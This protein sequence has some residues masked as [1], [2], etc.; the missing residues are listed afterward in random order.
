MGGSISDD[1]NHSAN[2]LGY[3]DGFTG[4][5][6]ANAATVTDSGIRTEIYAKDLGSKRGDAA[7]HVKVLK[8]SKKRK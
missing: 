2:A 3:D 6:D 1:D 4:A 5:I 8:M 7:V